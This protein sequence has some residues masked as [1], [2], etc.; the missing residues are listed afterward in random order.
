M[1]SVWFC[2]NRSISF[3]V[4]YQH[5]ELSYKRLKMFLREELFL[6]FFSNIC[7]NFP[8]WCSNISNQFVSRCH[9][10]RWLEDCMLDK[11][12]SKSMA[13]CK[14]AVTPWLM[15]WRYCNLALRC[16]SDGDV[17]VPASE[18]SEIAALCS[19][20]PIVTDGFPSKSD[21]GLWNFLI[22]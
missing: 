11:Y 10:T 5:G 4:I 9:I 6:W 8:P 17:N 7:A 2:L 22:C 1:A 20:N 19:E 12:T 21:T 18:I 3:P 13:L 16:R 14:T 15:H